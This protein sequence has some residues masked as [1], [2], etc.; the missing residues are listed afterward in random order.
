MNTTTTHTVA[1]GTKTSLRLALLA[2]PALPLVASC[3]LASLLVTGCGG[4][5][6]EEVV[7]QTTAS[8]QS[9]A[10]A[11]VQL[12]GCV[13]DSKYMGVSGKAVHVRT[14]D[15]RTVGTAFTNSDGV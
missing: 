13:V 6:I 3:A 14:V 11:S 12:E 1:S 5:G 10:A 7:G 8:R 4:G 9:V 15:G 2:R